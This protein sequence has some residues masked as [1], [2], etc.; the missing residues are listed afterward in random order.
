MTPH[1][2]RP[3]GASPRRLVIRADGAARGNPGPA[4]AGAV[5]IDADRPDARDPDAPPLAVV[6]RALG[7]RTNNV[8]EY[9]AVV[10]ALRAATR[11]GAR[12]VDL[13]LDSKL[14]VEQLNGRWRVKDAKLQGLFG[15]A[16]RLLAGFERWSASHEPRAANRA[17]D[18]LANLAL[19]DP[20]AAAAAVRV[21]AERRTA[22]LDDDIPLR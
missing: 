16:Q 15:E 3:A 19:D 1:T 21:L 7:H 11:L 9:A 4:A 8:A 12:E 10:L 17:A 22:V 20:T 14:V 18:A 6:A 5:L 2:A 13:R